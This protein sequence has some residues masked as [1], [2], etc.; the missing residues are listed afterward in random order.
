MPQASSTLVRRYRAFRPPT[1]AD[2]RLRFS[3]RGRTRYASCASA[4]S[5]AATDELS[6][7]FGWQTITVMSTF[8]LAMVLHPEAFKKAQQELDV[9]IGRSRLPDDTDRENLPYLECLLKEVYR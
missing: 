4:D 6:V 2:V 1:P 3:Q 7:E 9:V 5:R 8:F